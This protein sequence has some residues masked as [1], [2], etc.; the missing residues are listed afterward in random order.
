MHLKTSSNSTNSPTTQFLTPGR[1]GVYDPFHQISMWGDFK[2]DGCPNTSTSMIMEVGTKLDSQSEDSSHG[3]QGPSNKFDHEATKIADKVLRRLAQNR[4]A[5][6][7]SRLRKKAYVQ[8]LETSRLKLLQ[9][10][11]EL[12]Q[13]RQQ[14]LYIGGG[15]DA[16]H[17]GYSTSLNSDSNISINVGHLVNNIC[18]DGYWV[19]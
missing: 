16:N 11:Q 10:E 17:M 14:G 19:A 6:R 2:I 9:L 8:Q 13:A 3:T 5:A 12:E 4:E 18:L 7:K 15:L 1:L